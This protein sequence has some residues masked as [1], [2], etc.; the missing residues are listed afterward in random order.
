MTNIQTYDQF[1]SSWMKS[2]GVRRIGPHRDK[3]GKPGRPGRPIG[4]PPPS[5]PK[6]NSK[7]PICQTDKL[8]G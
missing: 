5:K 2:E 4:F 6:P 3:P 1:V 7:Q 8:N